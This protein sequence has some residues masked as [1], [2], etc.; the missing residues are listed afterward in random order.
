VVLT[1]VPSQSN[2]RLIWPGGRSEHVTLTS[3]GKSGGAG[4]IFA[5][6]GKPDLLAKIYHSFTQPEQLARY[7][8]KIR[9]MIDNK[10]DLPPIPSE[11]KSI[12][13]LAWPVAVVME[14]SR[15]AGFAME[16]IDFDRTMELDYLLTRRQAA[17]EG[18]AVDFG[19]LLAVCYNLASLINCLH[20]KKIAVVDLKPINLKVYKTELY[21]SILDCDGFRIYSDSFRSEA[22]Q[23]TPEYLAP[24]FHDRAVSHP[25]SQDWFALATIIFRMLNY[26][27][28]PFSG[29]AAS[30]QRYPAELS[31]RIKLG[32]YPYGRVRNK[33]VRAAPA[34][35]HEAF[36]DRIRELFDR[37]FAGALGGRASAYEWTAVLADYANSKNVGYMSQCAKGHLQFSGKSCPTCLREAI[38]QGHVKRQNKFVTRIQTS[39]ARALSYVKKTLRGTQTSPFQAALAQGQINLVQLAPAP[40]S[41]RNVVSIE[42]LWIIG[43][44]IS[45]WWLR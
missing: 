29:I 41:S 10:P 4:E 43:L 37:S 28:H 13:Q 12:V 40:V 25:E 24:E 14:K 7:A 42:I 6:D 8:R 1:Q 11:Y 27:I 21:V 15:F 16:K 9:W 23:V 33:N 2:V 20:S 19:K 31:G 30:H 36:P 39:P 18:F 45:Y 26:G 32:L 3:I 38:I 35:V 22:P 17:E 34:S 44:L 5:I